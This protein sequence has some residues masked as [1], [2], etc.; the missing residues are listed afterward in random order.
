MQKEKEIQFYRIGD[1]PWRCD[2]EFNGHTFVI[3]TGFKTELMRFVSALFFA[4][5]TPT[6][7]WLA[8]SIEPLPRPKQ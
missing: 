4:S 6:T 2:V 3:S 1:G 5:R 8:G 7:V